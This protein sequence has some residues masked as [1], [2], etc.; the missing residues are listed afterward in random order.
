MKA[1]KKIIDIS[2]SETMSNKKRY[3]KRFKARGVFIREKT[4]L[5]IRNASHV[6][7]VRGLINRALDLKLKLELLRLQ[8]K[9]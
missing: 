9:V 2:N 6:I 1:I 3:A 5:K 4:L 8:I 7:T